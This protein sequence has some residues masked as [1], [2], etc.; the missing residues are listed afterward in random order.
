MAPIH[1]HSA[2]EPATALSHP[3]SLPC[4]TTPTD[5]PPL[6]NQAHLSTFTPGYLF[7]FGDQ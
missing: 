5:T 2:L 7:C 3:V 1:V 6:Q 4:L